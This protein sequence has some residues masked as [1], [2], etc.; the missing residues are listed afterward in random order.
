MSRTKVTYGHSPPTPIPGKIFIE[1]GDGLFATIDESDYGL[2]RSF[3]WSLDT[4]GEPITRYP[5]GDGS[6]SS[7]RMKT[8]ILMTR[9][10]KGFAV[11]YLDGNTLN[12]SR[13]NLKPMTLSEARTLDSQLHGPRAPRKWSNPKRISNFLKMESNKPEKKKRFKLVED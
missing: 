11:K 8:V 5:N 4:K 10:E 6:Y 9:M 12:C 7:V 1:V 13:S 2:V 3:Q